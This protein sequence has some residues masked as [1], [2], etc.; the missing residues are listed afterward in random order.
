[1]TS[2]A[3]L[4]KLLSIILSC[5]RLPIAPSYPRDW[6]VSPES[7]FLLHSLARLASKLYHKTK[8]TCY[9]VYTSWFGYRLLIRRV[10][11]NAPEI[12]ERSV[13][14]ERPKPCQLHEQTDQLSLL[15]SIPMSHFD[16]S[17]LSKFG[18]KWGYLSPFIPK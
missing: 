8:G 5:T 4:S 1:M 16:R 11:K 10:G 13:K 7:R 6:C 17:G 3:A 2:E 15:K 12:L 18:D 9:V 14:C